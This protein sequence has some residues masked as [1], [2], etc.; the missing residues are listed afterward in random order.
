M[1]VLLDANVLMRIVQTNSVQHPD[2]VA[3]SSNLR[4]LKHTQVIVPQ[5]L[6]EF[7]VGATRPV[8]NNGLGLS[9]VECDQTIDGFLKV[10]PLLEDPHGTFA[11]WRTLAMTNACHGKVAHDARYVS[12]MGLHGIK[13]L[14]S[15]NLGD[16]ARFTNIITLDPVEVAKPMYVI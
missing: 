5:S 2:A 11:N 16:F 9:V 14:L 7:W 10:F 8:A 3:S 15:F 6:Y 12:V 4:N 1:N 13:H